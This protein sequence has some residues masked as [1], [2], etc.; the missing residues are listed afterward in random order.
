MTD[1]HTLP[2]TERTSGLAIASLVLSCV[3]VV[4][5]PFGCIPGIICGH[6][7]RSDCRKNPAL[8]GDGTALAG[9]II[10]YLF[11]T[12]FLLVVLV[13]IAFTGSPDLG[14]LA[15]PTI[16]SP[17]A[18]ARKTPQRRDGLREM[19]GLLGL[20]APA[21]VKQWCDVKRHVLALWHSVR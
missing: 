17:S 21:R 16:E 19:R 1:A 18:M 13:F 3:T 14:A 9:L 20:R 4:F 12:L 8:R 10:G 6:L 7:A 2:T 11:V 15:N 5:G